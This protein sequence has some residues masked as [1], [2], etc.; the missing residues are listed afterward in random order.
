MELPG[1]HCLDQA[2]D[3]FDLDLPAREPSLESQKMVQLLQEAQVS[4]LDWDKCWQVW[5]GWD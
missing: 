2:Q 4:H 5:F 3:C 1:L